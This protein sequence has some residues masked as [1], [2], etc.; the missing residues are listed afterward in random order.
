V[1]TYDARDRTYILNVDVG[2]NALVQPQSAEDRRPANQGI[3]M[4]QHPSGASRASFPDAVRGFLFIALFV[5]V[6]FGVAHAQTHQKIAPPWHAPDSAKKVPNPVKPSAAGMK[7]AAGLFKENCASCHGQTG[8]GNGPLSHTLKVKPI[9]FRDS[10]EVKEN[11]D[12][13]LFWKMTVGNLPMPSW[14]QLSETQR[15]LL[16]NYIRTLSGQAQP[17]K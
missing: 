13:E 15:W 8:A 9:S 10:V 14:A 11:N 5:S 1:A 2:P 12:G 16:V 4:T 17:P 7:I 3:K 6:V